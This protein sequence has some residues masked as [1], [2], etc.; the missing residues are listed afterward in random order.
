MA[1]YTEN[2][3]LIMPEEGDYYNIESFND[4][5]EAMDVLM[6]ENESATTEI[7]KKIGTPE[8][9]ETLFSL[10]KSGGSVI[11]SIQRVTYSRPSSATSGSVEIKSVNPEKSVVIFERLYDGNPTEKINYTLT[12]TS[13]E[14]THTA[15][16]SSNLLVGFWIIEF[17]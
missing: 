6:A 1:T 16:S 9:G 2:Y 7:N 4:N 13:I 5:F 15:S 10:L 17:N 3:N 11:K 8:S 12:E 14:C